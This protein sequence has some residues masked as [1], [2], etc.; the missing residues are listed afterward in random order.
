M[1]SVIFLR[2]GWKE[3]RMARVGDIVSIEI[4]AMYMRV[5]LR[6]QERE[7]E[8]RGS[9]REV[10]ERLPGEYFFRANRNELVNLVEVA[11]VNA[12]TRQI[13]LVMRD[14]REVRVS[15]VR[16]KEFRKRWAL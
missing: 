8:V 4:S 3:C 10:E 9:L 12:M 13:M 5:R 15:R 2:E 14:G 7:I 1:E 6:G 16:S 11:R